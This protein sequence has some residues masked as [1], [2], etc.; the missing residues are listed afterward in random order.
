MLTCTR[1]G[2]GSPRICLITG[3]PYG[4]DYAECRLLFPEE[5]QRMLETG[6]F[7]VLGT[8]DDREFKPTDLTGRIT[9]APDVGGMRGRKLHALARKR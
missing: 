2:R 6:G 3:R 5:V 8:Y 9:A 4:E 7:Q 1:Q